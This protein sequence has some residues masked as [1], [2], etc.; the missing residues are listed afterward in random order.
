MPIRD[1]DM[2]ASPHIISMGQATSDLTAAPGGGEGGHQGVHAHSPNAS[3]GAEGVVEHRRF[4]EGRGVSGVGAPVAA[5]RGAS[6]IDG[7]LSTAAGQFWVTFHLG[8]IL[9]LLYRVGK[10]ERP[11]PFSS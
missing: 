3:A 1:M 8:M 6:G 2:Y 4:R 9:L 7:V 5:N 10:K 11:F